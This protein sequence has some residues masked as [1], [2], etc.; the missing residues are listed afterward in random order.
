VFFP[1]L[2]VSRGQVQITVFKDYLTRNFE[3]KDS[4]EGPVILA[5]PSLP[6]IGVTSWGRIV[7]VP[8]PSRLM[9]HFRKASKSG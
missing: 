6:G 1:G 5:Q 4:T 3:R 9:D 2:F 7:V 8:D